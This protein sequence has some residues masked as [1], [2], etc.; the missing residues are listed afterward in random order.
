[1]NEVSDKAKKREEVAR[2]FFHE[3]RER[4]EQQVVVPGYKVEVSLEGLHPQ[5]HHLV[6][7]MWT[8]FSNHVK[9]YRGWRAKRVE[10]TEEEKRSL[11]ITKSGALFRYSLT[12][13]V[14]YGRPVYDTSSASTQH[15]AGAR[16]YAHGISPNDPRFARAS[17]VGNY[18]YVPHPGS[19][20]VLMR[21]PFE[22]VPLYPPQM[23]HSPRDEYA[24]PP[25]VPI[26]PRPV[27]GQENPSLD[28]KMERFE[29]TRQPFAHLRT[30]PQRR[31]VPM[32]K[33][34]GYY[35][36]PSHEEVLDD[37]P[38]PISS[39]EGLPYGSL[40]APP[41]TPAD[42][43][44]ARQLLDPELSMTLDQA[45]PSSWNALLESSPA[46]SEDAAFEHGDVVE[47]PSGEK[48]LVVEVH[49]SAVTVASPKGERA[50]MLADELRLWKPMGKKE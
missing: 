28:S 39:P 17:R 38:L 14:P 6:P 3:L 48:G 33:P 12:Y 26:V 15:A 44:S 11:R 34:R 41:P 13:K 2:S 24:P 40:Q 47:T 43:T 18:A 49:G 19:P 16:P 1:M 5:H 8:K 30:P 21:V 35:G 25:P 50:Q 9:Q 45:G 32:E 4:T 29:P 27:A 36:E 20:G 7:R 22:S 31:P 42:N 46:S 10:L 37:E 23:M